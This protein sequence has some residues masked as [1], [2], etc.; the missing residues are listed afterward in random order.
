V[1]RETSC[2]SRCRE[3]GLGR[4]SLAELAASLGL[5]VDLGAEE[6][7]DLDALYEFDTKRRR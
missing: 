3:L 2:L 1:L 6:E 7:R 4:L 5:R